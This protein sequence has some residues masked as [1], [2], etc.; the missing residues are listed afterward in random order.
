VNLSGC[1]T[2]S[3]PIETRLPLVTITRLPL[4]NELIKASEP[5]YQHSTSPLTPEEIQVRFQ[6]IEALITSGH[7]N[8]A[9]ENADAINPADLSSAQ[10]SQLNLLY[11][12]ILLN[13]G[14]AEQAIEKLVT[15]EPNQLEHENKIKYFQ[16]QAFAFA[17]TNNLLESAKSRIELHNLLSEADGEKNQVAIIEIL[18]FLPES[19]LQNAQTNELAG[20]M[21]LAKLSKRI[22][23]SEFAD[24]LSQWRAAFPDHPANEA[25]LIQSHGISDIPVDSK[26]MAILLPESGPFAEAGKAIRAGF[27]A[28]YNHAKSTHRLQFY[29]TSQASF[30]NLY[31]LA[32]ADGATFMI[33]PLDK[34][35][36]QNL[37]NSTTL[38][39]PLLALNHIEGL[40]KENLYQFALSPI[41]DVAQLSNKLRQDGY[42]NVVTLIPD[43]A[44]GQRI[45]NY[46]RENV[47]NFGGSLLETQAYNVKETD[48]S[49]TIKKLLNV[50]ES[51]QRYQEILKIIPAA[52]YAPRRRQDVQAILLSARNTEA[53]YINP[54]LKLYNPN[55]LPVY[56]MPNIYSGEPNP[57]Q[58]ADLN[59]IN[60]CDIPWFFNKPNPDGMNI[61]ALKESWKNI[62]GEYLKLF[63]MGIDA[64]SLISRLNDLKENEYQGVTGLLS[65]TSENRVKRGLVCAS[66]I[67]G[68]PEIVNTIGNKF[69]TDQ[70]Q[71]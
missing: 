49:V 27:M 41:D 32:L 46:F 62:S 31:N 2:N 60:F 29:D 65:L 13:F 8:T 33:G 44:S 43:N 39:I 4:K 53:R 7:D 58:D 3:H 34:E 28:A 54:Q 57:S 42:L 26:S 67:N 64:F 59:G 5:L 40:Q 16:S 55:S 18:N 52:I 68:R 21:S 45:N 25:L 35:S 30:P 23:Q 48:L 70:R 37:A 19:A 11:A 50:D 14:E 22:N 47:E 1:R 17:L 10:Q 63:A 51:G 56:A 15:I 9:K 69:F 36:I 12:Q 71:Y 24:Q 6:T 61:S 38:S 20:W 66:F